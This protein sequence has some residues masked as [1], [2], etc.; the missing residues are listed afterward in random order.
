MV[1]DEEFGEFPLKSS[2]VGSVADL[3]FY[4]AEILQMLHSDVHLPS[5]KSVSR[6]IK[7]H[8]KATDKNVKEFL[9]VRSILIYLL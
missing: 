3:P 7:E 8:K 5:A 6:D 4:V 9:E 2:E 1:D